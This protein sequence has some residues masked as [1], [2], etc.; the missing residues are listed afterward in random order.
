MAIVSEPAN[1]SES[2]DSGI[3]PSLL[4]YQCRQLSLFKA[5]NLPGHHFFLKL[6]EASHGTDKSQNHESRVWCLYYLALAYFSNTSLI[7]KVHLDQSVHQSL[8]LPWIFSSLSLLTWLPLLWHCFKF[9]WPILQ[10]QMPLLSHLFIHHSFMEQILC[11]LFLYARH[12]VKHF[13]S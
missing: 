4:A 1:S 6:S 10:G 9:N 11:K 5:Q 8:N 13:L 7:P 12:C 2:S 3:S